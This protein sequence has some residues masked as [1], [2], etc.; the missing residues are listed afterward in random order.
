M[1]TRA[2]NSV[3]S[4]FARGGVLFAILANSIV[5]QAAPQY[6]QGTLSNL[7]VYGDGTVL[8]KV[9]W[10]G[11]YVSVCNVNTQVASATQTSCVAWVS[12]M[13][14]AISRGTQTLMYYADAPACN[15]MPTYASSPVPNYVMMMN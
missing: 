3:I 13:R 1:T 2:I 15:V 10:L 4:K 6:C 7:A 5:T 9:S 11:D 14:S 12:L 8:V